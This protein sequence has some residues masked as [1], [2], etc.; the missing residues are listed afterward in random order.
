[1]ES[2]YKILFIYALT[3]LIWGGTWYAIRVSLVDMT[4]L[5]SA[6]FRFI[7][8]TALIYLFMRIKGVPLP[9][10]RQS[11]IL[12][13]IMSI[14]SFLLPFGFVYW[15]EKYVPSGLAAV[16]FAIYPFVAAL[17]SYFF[18]KEEKI[19]FFKIVGM[20]ISFAGIVIIFSDQFGGN[21]SDYLLGMIAITL[22]GIMQASIAVTIKKFGKGLNPLSM[23]LLP[24]GISGV[25]MIALGF[26]LE[27]YMKLNFTL[28]SGIAIFYLA[29]F[30][31]LISFT[32]YYWLLKRINII[33]LS[34]ISFITPI[35]ALFVGWILTGEKLAPIQIF[36]SF[37]VLGGI[38][39]A[40]L[41][42]I[43][44]RKVKMVTR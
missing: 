2:K 21:M 32:S 34:L 9:M 42:N 29:F 24:M 20:V 13:L 27:D 25:L 6:G 8:A 41:E 26:L 19:G 7:L 17:L 30:G 40:L 38:L 23:N 22:S 35:I 3:C 5:F 15:G 4:P 39:F 36:G 14:F 44:P 1:M 12:Y 37:F 16:L 31:S 43:I 33:L 28:N 11:V 10:D 18:L